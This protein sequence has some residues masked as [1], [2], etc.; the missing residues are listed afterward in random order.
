MRVNVFHDTL[1]FYSVTKDS[2][3]ISPSRMQLENSSM[4]IKDTSMLKGAK[5]LKIKNLRA[6]ICV[7]KSQLVP[8][9]SSLFRSSLDSLKE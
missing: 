2:S 5:V 7:G 4:G 6:P 3:S 9:N 1:R 8:S